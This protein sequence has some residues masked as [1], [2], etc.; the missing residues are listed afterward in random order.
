MTKHSIQ[1]FCHGIFREETEEIMTPR[2]HRRQDVCRF[3]KKKYIL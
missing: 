1:V 2:G 3:V